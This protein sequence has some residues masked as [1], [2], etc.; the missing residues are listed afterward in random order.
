MMLVFDFNP[1][2]TETLNVAPL[3][4]AAVGDAL[5][6]QNWGENCEKIG[7]FSAA[8][9]LIYERLWPIQFKITLLIP[10]GN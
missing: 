2:F 5:T 9:S 4:A 6:T 1:M 10:K 3:W 7:K 8:V